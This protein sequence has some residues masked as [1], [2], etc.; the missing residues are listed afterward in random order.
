RNDALFQLSIQLTP[1]GVRA[2]NQIV[3]LVFHSIAQLESRGLFAWR[4]AELQQMGDFEFRFLER[5]PPMQT[6]SALA[7]LMKTVKPTDILRG[8]YLYSA[9][10]ERLIK[11]AL[12]HLNSKNVLMVLTAPEITPYRVSALYSTPFSVRAGI[13]ELWDLKPGVRKTLFLPEKNIF[14]PKRLTVKSGSLLEN[15]A[16]LDPTPQLILANKNMRTWF[17][18]DQQFMQPRALIKLRIKSP[19]VSASAEGAAQAQLFAELIA[20]QMN[21]FSYAAHLAGIEHSVIANTRGY[22]ISIFGY[23]S[24]QGL[25]M[26]KM[27]EAMRSTAFKEERFTVLKE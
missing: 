13:P 11:K 24:R 12:S 10:D 18:Q 8:P 20:D 15:N 21:E 25:L 4:Y 7:Q 27:M 16:V 1:Q 3:S 17:A 19:L 14:I 23:S 5:K 26:N 9:F 6:V 2:R 22:Q